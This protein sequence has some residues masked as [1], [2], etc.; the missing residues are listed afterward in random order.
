MHRREPSAKTSRLR[1]CGITCLFLFAAIGFADLML[2]L[3]NVQGTI[4]FFNDGA[5]ATTTSNGSNAGPATM[6]SKPTTSAAAGASTS[7][8]GS[9]SGSS[10]APIPI[11]TNDPVTSGDN[12]SKTNEVT[13][14][15]TNTDTDTNTNTNTGGPVYLIEH[16]N[17]ATS[18]K[19]LNCNVFGGPDVKEK[20]SRAM[21]YW[22]I[23][24]QDK[25][26]PNPIPDLDH[27]Y[28]TFQVDEHEGVDWDGHHLAM[29][30]ALALSFATGRTLV[31]PP[32]LKMGLAGGVSASY[33]SFYD[34]KTLDGAYDGIHII[35]MDQF[36]REEGMNGKLV[37]LSSGQK[38]DVPNGITDWSSQSEKKG[39]WEYLEKVGEIPAW[40]PDECIHLVPNKRKDAKSYLENMAALE[41]QLN[42]LT[43]GKSGRV[44]EP[45]DYAGSPVDVNALAR[46]RLG[47][48]L[49]GRKEKCMYNEQIHNA[50]LVY[51][52]LDDTSS[53]DQSI[54]LSPLSRP[55]YSFIFF[56]NWK[57]DLWMKRL[58][59]DG[60][61]YKDDLICAAA[62]VTKELEGRA[63][64]KSD[65]DSYYTFS[66]ARGSNFAT[67]HKISLE[68]FKK[69]TDDKISEGK[70]VYI[71]G[72][73][74]KMSVFDSL[75]DKFDVSS[76]LDY[77]HLL[78]DIEPIYFP[79]VDQLV[80]ARGLEHLPGFSS[81][82]G[83]LYG[84]YSGLKQSREM[85][86][87]YYGTT[88]EHFFSLNQ[89]FSIQEFPISWRYLDFS[90]K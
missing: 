46:D 40:L 68:E 70:T 6:E 28:L 53:P 17:A 25:A 45:A 38:I 67:Q 15:E 29:E 37:D 65:T 86:D 30:S 82:S 64:S 22:K 69:Q 62:R 66:M 1:C 10:E 43:S 61:R 47:E 11:E 81:Y 87:F 88:S 26:Y 2:V 49:A 54:Y 76:L 41:V 48:F 16:P 58:M 73:L 55:F 60:L 23:V 33:D 57:D 52:K 31:L 24:E 77:G 63:K 75:T 83:R 12:T 13:K 18:D 44:P 21:S 89:P 14:Q 42:D 3:A 34:L 7:S 59:R 32:P 39:L 5:G 36:L 9:N 78:P 20:H 71:A 51:I 8:S 56:E 84:Y 79:L 90:I 50:K 72:A 74:Q 80:A 19:F 35:T 27:R 85:V 4:D